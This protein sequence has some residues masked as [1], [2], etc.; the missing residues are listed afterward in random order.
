MKIL[1]TFSSVNNASLDKVVC[2]ETKLIEPSK[3]K[4]NSLEMTF[5]DGLKY[6]TTKYRTP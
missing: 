3:L 5:D 6:N 1:Q 2:F 4:K